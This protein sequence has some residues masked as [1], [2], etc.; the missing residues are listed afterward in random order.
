MTRMRHLIVLLITGVSSVVA[1]PTAWAYDTVT[2]EVISDS[3]GAANI[4]YF[5]HSQRQVLNGAKLPWRADVTVVDPHSNS[6]EGAEVRADWRAYMPASPLPPGHPIGYWVTVR[7]SLRGKVIC[8][9]TLDL[10]DAACYG[11][12]TFLS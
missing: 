2:Y 1:P 4:E 11:S 7:I 10:G 3:V 5:D 9:N 6:T 12:T 8:Q